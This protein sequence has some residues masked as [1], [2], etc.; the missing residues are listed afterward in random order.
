MD[1]HVEILKDSKIDQNVYFFAAHSGYGENN[2]FNDLAL[3]KVGDL[4]YLKTLED[5]LVYQVDQFYFIYKNG[6]LSVEKEL[7]DVIFLITCSLE[8]P[9]KQLII[10]GHLL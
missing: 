5:V 4:I 9:D 10:K 1:F 7:V 2:Y 8:Y 3:L 6:Y